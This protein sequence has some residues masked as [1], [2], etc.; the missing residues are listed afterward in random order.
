MKFW[1]I[2]SLQ[3]Y[4]IFLAAWANCGL[5]RKT[6]V[7]NQNVIRQ[8]IKNVIPRRPVDRFSIKAR[9]CFLPSSVFNLNVKQYWRD[10]LQ[11]LTRMTSQFIN[12]TKCPCCCCCCWYWYCQKLVSRC[13]ADDWASS[14]L[15]TEPNAFAA[16]ADTTPGVRPS[17][18][19]SHSWGLNDDSPR[20]SHTGDA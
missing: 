2:Y 15:R 12:R 9:T 16:G 3:Y 13:Y 7:Y 17:A 6:Q 1:C 11:P 20:T 5:S 19:P 14:E 4:S 8:L 18:G 10:E